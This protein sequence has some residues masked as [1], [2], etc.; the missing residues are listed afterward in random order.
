MK[1]CESQH[2][3]RMEPHV[4]IEVKGKHNTAPCYCGGK[5]LGDGAEVDAK[6]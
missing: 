3:N 1:L 4:M 5:A 2:F 6:T